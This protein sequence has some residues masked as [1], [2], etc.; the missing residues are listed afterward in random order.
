MTLL[1]KKNDRNDLHTI[2]VSFLNDGKGVV[3]TYYY[4]EAK[5]PVEPIEDFR[6]FRVTKLATSKVLK[7]DSFWKSQ[8]RKF[9][10]QLRKFDY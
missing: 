8:F 1:N 5:A 2:S 6:K 7:K 4:G 3:E 9:M 10:K